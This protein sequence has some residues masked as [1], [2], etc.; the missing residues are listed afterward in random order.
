MKIPLLSFCIFA[1]VTSYAQHTTV[2]TPAQ[3]KRLDSIA[4]QDVPASAPGIATGIVRNGKI[5][6]EKVAGF[7]DLTDSTII[8]RYT[9]FNIA[10]NGK[11]FTALAI[12]MLVDSKKISLSDD[13][14]KYLPSVY[15]R[16][17]KKI[18]I[19]NLLNHTSGIRDVYD[20]WALKGIT[21]WKQSFSNKDVLALVEKQE[22][23]NFLPGT[24]YLY[25]NTNY[26]LLTAIAEKVTGE[27][28]VAFTNG[29]FKKLDMPNTSFED[30]H[31]AIRGPVAKAYF[32]FGTWTTYNW[33]W[34]VC[35]D[36]NIFSTLADQ[37]R[38]EQ[39]LQGKV[40]TSIKRH[41]LEKS[42]QL[43]EHSTITNYGYGLEFGQYKGMPYKFHEGAT[44]AWK[45]TVI[46]FPGK[47][48]A[49]VTLTNTGKSTPNTQ[50]RQMADV[51]FD[52][53]NNADYII[54][55]PAKAGN[56]IS[57]EDITGIYQTEDNFTFQFEKRDSH[58][59]LKRIGRND[60]QLEREAGNIYHQTY[61][62]DF[63][64]EFK[65]NEKG[66]MTVTA[67]YT[68]HAPYTL[69][70]L[71]ADWTGYDYQALNGKYFNSE[72]NVTIA[73]RFS[74]NKNYNITIGSQN[75]TKGLL[76]SPA[77]MLVD[78]YVIE[79]EKNGPVPNTLFLSSD[80]IKQVKFVRIN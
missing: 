36:G 16:L 28:F 5:V 70:R 66:E 20:L 17:T 15:P 9:R 10:S 52:L 78:F 50:T 45:A 30:D 3:V 6:Y 60:V 11:Q 33:K 27:S 44:G 71:A 64:Q 19:E 65:R 76:I 14:R 62:P 47:K 51:V 68:S 2:F 74:D 54:T 22:D 80:R 7:A 35:G 72:T 8:T 25:S 23:V 77:K 29:L 37:L 55:Q 24:K 57:D 42:Q 79:P 38:W 34:N 49:I 21:W 41:I 13:I 56:F 18:T 46:R 69:T 59:Y 75:S 73:I 1:N 39:I 32:N 48:T 31:S 4:L 63:K 53:K 40:K 26:I 12:L 67:Y 43:T 61:D 58:I